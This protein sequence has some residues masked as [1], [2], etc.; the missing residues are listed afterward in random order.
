LIL[1]F[2]SLTLNKNFLDMDSL[3]IDLILCGLVYVILIYFIVTVSKNLRVG[4][5]DQD[6]G[7]DGGLEIQRPPKID[8]PPG[9]IWPTGELPKLKPSPKKIEF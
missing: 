6:D 7:G 8:L 5:N 2:D 4:R 1:I 3:M 9:V